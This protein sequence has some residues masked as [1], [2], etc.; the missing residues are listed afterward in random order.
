MLN[1]GLSYS[2]GSG[3]STSKCYFGENGAFFSSHDQKIT[4]AGQW[5][6]IMLIMVVHISLLVANLTKKS[7]LIEYNW[8]VRVKEHKDRPALGWT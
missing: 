4:G 2:S 5:R 8:H 3:N 1:R 7:S 6:E